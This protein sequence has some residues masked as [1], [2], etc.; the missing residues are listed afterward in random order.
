MVLTL[1]LYFCSALE[2]SL[3]VEL[4]K[5]NPGKIS[6]G[7]PLKCGCDELSQ[8]DDSAELLHAESECVAEIRS[9]L[10]QIKIN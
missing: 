3:W 4:P 9:D 10:K 2:S 7:A 8:S 1:I 6:T 5:N